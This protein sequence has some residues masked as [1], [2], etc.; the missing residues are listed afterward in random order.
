MITKLKYGNTN[1]W[2]IRGPHG[3]ILLDTDYAGTLPLFYK[4]I[5]KVQISIRDLSYIL[6]THYHPDHMGIISDL[7]KE[8]VALLIMEPQIPYVHYSDGI[9][10]RDSR[11]KVS[12]IREEQAVQLC[13]EESRSF[14]KKLGIDGEIISTPSHSRDS[15]SL[16]L[17]SGACFV[18][19]LQPREY[20]DGFPDDEQFRSDWENILTAHPSVIYYSHI[21]EQIVK[22]DH[23]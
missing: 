8:G 14:L 15:I 21:P 23:F 17:D 13:C 22:P 12:P 16:L 3:T 20:L 10:A 19:D 11:L 5:K 7:M 18:G 6:A 1:T 4:A 9:F 2:L